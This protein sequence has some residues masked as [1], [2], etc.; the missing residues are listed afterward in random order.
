M[1]RTEKAEKHRL[2]NSC[3][4]DEDVIKLLIGAENNTS[5]IVLCEKCRY[6]IVRL[7]CDEKQDDYL[8]GIYDALMET[9]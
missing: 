5:S 9:I 7:F 1:I 2:C 8:R 3:G 6:E 4:S